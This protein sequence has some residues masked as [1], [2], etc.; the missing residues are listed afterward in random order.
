MWIVSLLQGPECFPP[1]ESL[2]PHPGRSWISLESQAAVSF[3][4]TSHTQ[5]A[6]V[7]TKLKPTEHHPG[8]HSN[9]ALCAV[10]AAFG[11]W[12]ME[13]TP[14]LLLSLP[15][16]ACAV[17]DHRTLS[18]EAS[19]KWVGK[20]ARANDYPGL[21][22]T[23]ALKVEANPICLWCSEKICNPIHS[24]FGKWRWSFIPSCSASPGGF[25]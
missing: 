17:R 15:R 6:G 10:T 14:K 4:G 13:S 21:N 5:R 18:P 8:T 3:P 12:Q 16:K 7:R 11:K 9:Q 20:L 2:R 1:L 22:T 25:G 19:V 23:S 24:N